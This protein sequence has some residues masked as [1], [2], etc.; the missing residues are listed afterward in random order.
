MVTANDKNLDT[1]LLYVLAVLC[2]TKSSADRTEN[3]KKDTRKEKLRK[4]SS[5][6]NGRRKENGIV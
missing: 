4:D 3:T 1:I 2:R 5:H 6:R